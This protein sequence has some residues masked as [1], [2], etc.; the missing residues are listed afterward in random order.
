MLLLCL[1]GFL[2]LV[3]AVEV[4][5]GVTLVATL[6]LGLPLMYMDQ[7]TSENIEVKKEE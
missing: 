2:K 7:F 5:T 4:C 6:I 3:F 1:I